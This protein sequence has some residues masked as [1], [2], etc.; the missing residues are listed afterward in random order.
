VKAL[1]RI[2]DARQ[3]GLKYIANVVFVPWHPSIVDF[4]G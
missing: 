3:L 2:L 1:K 4:P